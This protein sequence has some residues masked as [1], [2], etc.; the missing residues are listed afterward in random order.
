MS[1]YAQIEALFSNI[2]EKMES[3]HTTW[4]SKPFT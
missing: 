3:G 4:S 1:A 2:M